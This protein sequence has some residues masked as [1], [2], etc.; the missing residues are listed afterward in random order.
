MTDPTETNAD[1]LQYPLEEARWVWEEAA[2][3]MR[4]HGELASL[5]RAK[6]RDR[7]TMNLLW[8]KIEEGE[9]ALALIGVRL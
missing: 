4:L 9:A 5:Y 7:G 1:Q 8:E 2:R 3:V 6:S